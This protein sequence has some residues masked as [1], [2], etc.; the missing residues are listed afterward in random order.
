MAGQRHAMLHMF[1]TF[2]ETFLC[3]LIQINEQNHQ[4]KVVLTG[5]PT[6]LRMPMQIGH[7]QRLAEKN[8]FPEQQ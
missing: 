6:P 2:N 3:L 4:T 1:M 7:F 8:R 5:R